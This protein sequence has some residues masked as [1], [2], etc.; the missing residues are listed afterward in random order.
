MAA[1][2][3]LKHFGCYLL[4]PQLATCSEAPPGGLDDG[5]RLTLAMELLGSLGLRLGVIAP[6]H[7]HLACGALAHALHHPRGQGLATHV[8]CAGAG[9]HEHH[10]TGRAPQLGTQ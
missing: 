3:G 8:A 2:S 6:Q 4:L 7:A 10:R 5:G 1:P 9:T